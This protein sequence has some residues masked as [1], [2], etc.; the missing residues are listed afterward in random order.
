MFTRSMLLRSAILAG[1]AFSGLA[2]DDRTPEN[3]AP[4][5]TRDEDGPAGS[6][7]EDTP[8]GSDKDG[9]DPLGEVT[10]EPTVLV[11]PL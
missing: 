3:P 6:F 11:R 10:L 5:G 8:D 4:A 7:V 9:E 2:Q 1:L